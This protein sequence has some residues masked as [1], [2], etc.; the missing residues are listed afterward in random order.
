M[1]FEWKANR[2]V[3]D[4]VIYIVTLKK[5]QTLYTGNDVE[6]RNAKFVMRVPVVC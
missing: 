6:F 2:N 3:I 5:G 4:A 1:G